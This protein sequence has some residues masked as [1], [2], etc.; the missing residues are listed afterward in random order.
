MNKQKRAKMAKKLRDIVREL[1]NIRRKVG[2]DLIAFPFD[3]I[4]INDDLTSISDVEALFHSSGFL[5][6]RGIPVFVY[7]RDHTARGYGTPQKANKIHFYKC[8][9]LREMEQEGKFQQRYRKTNRDDNRYLIDVQK[10]YGGSKEKEVTLYPCQYCLRAVSYQCFG[11]RKGQRGLSDQEKRIIKNFDAK[12]AFALIR[13]QFEIFR[14][15]V[16]NPKLSPANIPAGYSSSWQRIS[17]EYRRLKGYACEQCGVR[18]Q[19][20]P[21]C[22]DVHHKDYDKQNILNSNLICLCKCCHARQHKHYRLSDHCRD[23]IKRAQISQKDY[24]CEQCGV[25]L[26]DNPECLD[27]YHKDYDKQNVL[28]SNFICLCKCCHARQHKHHRLSD[29]CRELIKREQVS[30]KVQRTCP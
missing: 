27:V 22:L 4:L 26:Q 6:D 19:D 24:T 14:Q 13:Q 3:P 5:V 10:S 12:V 30:Q 29:H 17:R 9:K 18:L 2:A 28:S 7:I 23:I 11:Q 15:E 25:R 21:G 16:Q 1:R 8:A 20:A